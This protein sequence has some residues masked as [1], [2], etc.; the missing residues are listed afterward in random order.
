MELLQLPNFAFSIAVAHFQLGQDVELAHHLLQ[1]ALIMFPGVL[2]PLL[3]KCGVQPDSRVSSHLFFTT[4]DTSVK[5]SVTIDV[6]RCKPGLHHWKEV[7]VAGCQIWAVWRLM[8]H[9]LIKI[10]QDLL[11]T[12]GCMGTCIVAEKQNF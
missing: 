4:A 5:F 12:I 9:F 11:C 2:V 7:V 10:I 1:N 6:L 3:T 8:K